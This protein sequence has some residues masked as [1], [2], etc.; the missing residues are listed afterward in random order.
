MSLELKGLSKSFGSLI[1]ND[2][3]DLAVANGE[4]H[5]IL[6][7]NGAGK[8]TLMNMVYGLLQPDSGSIYVDGKKVEINEPADALNFGI[9]MVADSS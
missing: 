2:A 9:G 7:E 3:I 5:A 1:A 6:G 8:S 4:I